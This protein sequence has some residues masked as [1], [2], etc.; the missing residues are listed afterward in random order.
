[1]NISENQPKLRMK[2]LVPLIVL[3][4]VAVFFA[5]GCLVITILAM[6]FGFG[7]TLPVRLLGVLALV[8]GFSSS[9]GCSRKTADVLA[10]TYVT[11]SKVKKGALLEKPS[12]RTEPES[13]APN[14][15]SM[16]STKRNKDRI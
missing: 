3:V 12:G 6:P 2:L 4:V 7:F 8:S 14:I 16:R 15:L 11:F 9:V 10:S 5:L 13:W 1:M